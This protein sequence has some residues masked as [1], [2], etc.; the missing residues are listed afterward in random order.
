M[1]IEKRLTFTCVALLVLRAIQALIATV[2]FNREDRC[3]Q[4][5]DGFDSRDLGH[6]SDCN[7]HQ[8]YPREHVTA[9]VFLF[10]TGN[11]EGIARTYEKL[12]AD[13]KVYDVSITQAKDHRNFEQIGP[14]L[15]NFNAAW[16]KVRPLSRA[17]KN[18]EAYA[19]FVAEAVPAMDKLFAHVTKMLE[20]N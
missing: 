9:S 12:S 6:R 13:L 14:L 2:M 20:W 8:G 5:G 17:S 15:E 3:V 18:A 4:P 19:I 10:R 11:E 7:R 16:L 1:T